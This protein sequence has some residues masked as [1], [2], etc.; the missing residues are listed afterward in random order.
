M[1]QSV[2]LRKLPGR[3]GWEFVHPPC[4][5]ERHEDLEE[6]GRMLEA[7]EIVIARDELLWLLHECPNFMAAHRLLGEIALGEENYR[8]GRGHFGRAFRLGAIAIEKACGGQPRKDRPAAEIPPAP[9]GPVPYGLP[10]NQ[11]FHE[12][13]KGLVYC[14]LKLGKRKLARQVAHLLLQCDPADPLALQA[15]VGGG[16]SAGP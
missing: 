13:G 4:A 8:L 3:D 5:H 7:G 6:V 2:T 9:P 10:G 1:K 12:S 14:L 15:L 11:P 16:A